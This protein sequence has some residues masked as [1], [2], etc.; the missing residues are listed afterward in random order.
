[1]PEIR[2]PRGGPAYRPDPRDQ[3]LFPTE[4][5]PPRGKTQAHDL[6]VEIRAGAA[7]HGDGSGAI[8]PL[9]V[10]AGVVAALA[11]LIQL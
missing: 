9:S 8:M 5:V 7:R 6:G 4:E 3:S 2:G 11:Q 1:M 10:T